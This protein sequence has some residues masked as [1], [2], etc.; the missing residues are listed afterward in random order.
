MALESPF[1]TLANKFSPAIRKG[2][3]QAWND[4]RTQF[5][6]AEI[7]TALTTGGI[8]AVMR[9]Y[10]NVA[11]KTAKALNPAIDDAIRAGADLTLETIPPVAFVSADVSVSLINANTVAYLERY[12]LN[13]INTISS[14]TTEAIRESLIQDTIAGVSPRSTARNFRNTIGLTPHQERAVR[15]YKKYLQEG[16]S[17]ALQRALRDKRSDSVV[18]RA[19][20]GEQ[21]LTSQQIERLSNRYRE[22]YIKHRSE[23]IARTESLR[24]VGI[25]NRAAI[26]TMLLEGDVLT[27]D[28]R[29]FWKF[30][31][32]GRTRNE[33]RKIPG[34]NPD[35][36]KLDEPFQTPL[37]PLMFPRDPDGTAANT[38]Q[39]RCVEFYRVVDEATEGTVIQPETKTPV[40][41]LKK[42]TSLGEMPT[43]KLPSIIESPEKIDAILEDVMASDKYDPSNRSQNLFMKKANPVLG[44][45]VSPTKVSA[46]EFDYLLSNS[47]ADTKILYRGV[48]D[49][50]FSD[51]F[52][53]GDLF[54]GQGVY[55]DGTY[56]SY[57]EIGSKGT[58]KSFAAEIAKS[59]AGSSGGQTRMLLKSDA[60]LV[61]FEDARKEAELFVNK[62]N[63]TESQAI[64]DYRRAGRAKAEEIE[65]TDSRAADKY[66][67]NIMR[68]S[69]EMEDALYEKT[70]YLGDPGTHA[71]LSGYDGIVVEN[72][73][74]VV[75]LNRGAVVIDD[76]VYSGKDLVEAARKM[77]GGDK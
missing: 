61:S 17:Q 71:L 48:T 42:P 66:H 74:Y 4:L 67:D 45:D 41:E 57:A 1:I 59:Y 36:V 68:T 19:I 75:L 12:K 24:A 58:K 77:E 15:N 32:D 63:K 30:T 65:V 8:E 3:I 54:A 29:R 44:A 49:K 33:H 37:G 27:E 13:L 62:M 60:N 56:T 76:S 11:L 46:S 70:R 43:S 73:G 6:V 39:C 55:G 2:L 22:R 34:M 47:S 14:N 53:S 35:G 25:G 50:K 5:T 20:S 28:V 31:K 18:A 38:I 72:E 51:E 40:T 9:M 69:R 26:N 7:E 52:I 16:D 21:P 10:D 64:D 23:V